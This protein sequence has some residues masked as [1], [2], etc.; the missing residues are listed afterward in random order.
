[1]AL[2][3]EGLPNIKLAHNLEFSASSVPHDIPS[4]NHPQRSV[5]ANGARSR[6]RRRGPPA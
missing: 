6:A 1:M 2:S 4:P 3:A 5:G